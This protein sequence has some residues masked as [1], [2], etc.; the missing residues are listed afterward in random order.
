MK[1]VLASTSPRRRQ[2][3]DEMGVIYTA[4]NPRFEESSRNDLSSEEEARL[5]AFEKANSVAAEFPNALII[6]SD[7]LISCE[8]RKI[9][10]PKDAEDARAMLAFLCNRT[11][12]IYTAASI[13]N[14]ATG[15]HS[16]HLETIEV[17]MR[18][19]SADEI[20]AYVATGEPLDKAGAYAIQGGGKDFITEVKGDYWAAVGLPVQWLSDQLQVKKP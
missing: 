15:V 10:K 19:A 17:T 20:A 7:T 3:L 9:G 6:G 12:H 13:L 14:T 16:E 5:F 18:A 2:I 8:G 1:L 11:H 4:V